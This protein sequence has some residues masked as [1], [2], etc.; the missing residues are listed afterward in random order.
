MTLIKENHDVNIRKSKKVTEK[1]NLKPKSSKIKNLKTCSQQ[2]SPKII[3]KKSK[4]NQNGNS[5]IKSKADIR[6]L[7]DKNVK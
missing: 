1:S 4:E 3:T 6:K 5:W 2:K 7:Y